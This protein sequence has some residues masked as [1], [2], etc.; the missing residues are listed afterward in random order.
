MLIR[1]TEERRSTLI[2]GLCSGPCRKERARGINHLS[3]WASLLWM[4]CEQ[5]IQICVALTS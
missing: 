2:A 4:Q 5:L 3:L 1:L